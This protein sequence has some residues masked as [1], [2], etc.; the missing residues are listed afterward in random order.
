MSAV[1]KKIKNTKE[2]Y[3]SFSLSGKK[4]YANDNKK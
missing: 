1:K 2:D 3:D 4:K